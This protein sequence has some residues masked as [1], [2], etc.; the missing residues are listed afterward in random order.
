L[1]RVLQSIAENLPPLRGIF[2]EAGVLDDGVLSQQ[3]WSRFE[4]VMKPKAHGAWLL[5]SLTEHMPLDFFVL[6][7]SAAAVIGSAGQGNYAAANAF[8]DGLAHYRRA[9]GLPATSI[10]WGAWAEVGMAASLESAGS[11]RRAARDGS[12][13]KPEEGLRILEQLISQQPVQRVVLPI[14]LDTMEGKAVQPIL[15]QVVKTKSRPAQSKPAGVTPDQL[16]GMPPAAQQ[17]ALLEY[18][19]QQVIGILGLDPRQPFNPESVLTHLGMDS[20]M[21]VELKNKIEGDLG[22]NVPVTY[23]LEEATVRD[24]AQLLLDR[25]TGAEQGAADGGSQA[26]GAGN[27]TAGEGVDPEKARRLLSNLDQL[28]EDEVNALL[29]DLMTKEEE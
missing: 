10:N 4:R 21:A 3:N 12:S 7:S 26:A 1:E 23:F 11:N 29:N 17:D 16:K 18:T 28:S 2:H 15:R 6:F 13:I 25:L 19:R 14:Q 27:G 22:V 9:R 20:L 24:L 5:H 8:M